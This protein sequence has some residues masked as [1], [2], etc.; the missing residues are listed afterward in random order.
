MDV[1]LFTAEEPLYLPRYLEPVVAAHDDAITAIVIAQPASGTA[2]ELHRQFRLFGPLAFLRMGARFARGRLLDA[3]PFGLGRRLTG[4]Y[5][6]VATLAADHHIPVR[7]TPDV[8]APAFVESIVECDPDVVLSIVCG[9]KL[10]SRVLDVAD[11]AIN[12]HGSL[13]PRYRGRAVAFWPLYYGDDRTGVTAH[14]MTDAFDAGPIIEQ[15]SFE[16]AA[17]DS[18]H[19]VS[20]K[21]AGVGSSLATDLLDRLPGELETRPNPTG[22]ADY[23]TLPT[24]EER[25]D[26]LQRGNRF[27]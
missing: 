7:R 11:A 3:L 9:Q 5:H 18:M 16:I 12:L 27:V 8:S 26:F 22:P 24:A 1:V 2:A 15:R 13:L 25:R 21:L 14:L 20:L 17:A 19:D 10:P 4:R 6:G 23:H